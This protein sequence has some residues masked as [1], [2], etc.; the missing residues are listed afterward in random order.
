MV[1]AS[2]C[3][4]D[5]RRIYIDAQVVSSQ[6]GKRPVGMFEESQAFTSAEVGRKMAGLTIKPPNRLRPHRTPSALVAAER[7]IGGNSYGLEPDPALNPA[8]KSN[9][10]RGDRAVPNQVADFIGR[11][12]RARNDS[13]VRPSD[14]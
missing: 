5:R 13:N 8:L 9:L 7:E 11:K 12:W 4:S 6:V 14:S 2:E 3:E 10:G 1:T